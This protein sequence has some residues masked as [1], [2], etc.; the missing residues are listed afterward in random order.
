MQTV[1][2]WAPAWR[3]ETQQ[4]LCERLTSGSARFVLGFRG[5]PEEAVRSGR[6]LERLFWRASVF[7]L[8]LL[9][10][11]Q[12]TRDLPRLVERL[13]AEWSADHQRPSRG[14][15]AEANE[16]FAAYGWPGNLREVRDVLYESADRATG[17]GIDLADLPS[18]LRLALQLERE[19]MT[20]AK[21][22][23]LEETLE[24]VEARLIALALR[25]A[26]GNRTRAADLLGIPR[27]RLLRRI[28]AFG[29]GESSPKGES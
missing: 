22:L 25:R 12:R 9:P 10:L 3:A 7:R 8:D 26:E 14:L 1:S 24:A 20:N 5:D 18:R 19:P 13:L 23:S 28:E 29:L 2:P 15:T 17:E 16:A 21:P 6:L 4:S 11:R 27:S